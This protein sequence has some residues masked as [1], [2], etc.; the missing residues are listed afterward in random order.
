MEMLFRV[1]LWVVSHPLTLQGANFRYSAHNRT[2]LALIRRGVWFSVRPEA[3]L[4]SG[5]RPRTQVIVR[6]QRYPRPRIFQGLL[7]FSRGVKGMELAM[8]M[9]KR[10]NQH[11]MSMAVAVTCLFG[12]LPCLA[13]EAVVGGFLAVRGA[14]VGCESWTDRVLELVRL[15]S[16][17]PLTL[18]GLPG[19]DVLGLNAE[20][21]KELIE[22]G[23][24]QE[25]GKRPH[26]LTVEL[27]KI[28]AEYR[29]LLNDYKAHLVAL[30]KESCPSRP[31]RSI[32]WNE[33][34][35]EQMEEIRRIEI[36]KVLV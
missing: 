1:L 24:E 28:E 15:D 19:F 21:I 30:M 26:S 35:D 34:L 33:Q 8:H 12:S 4:A 2:P 13:E 16:E 27:L 7:N 31:R 23:V 36:S 6:L 29:L 22:D 17:Q 10:Q 20:E 3:E 14:I 18:L 25:A 32:P 11:T 5:T 9:F